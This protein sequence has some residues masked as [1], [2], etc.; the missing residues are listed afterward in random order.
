MESFSK[1]MDGGFL[2]EPLA[3]ERNPHDVANRHKSMDDLTFQQSST[4]TDLA[5]L[6]RVTRK[7]V[8]VSMHFKTISFKY[9]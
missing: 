8:L 4:G 1:S 9:I 6:L 3:D 5:R 2:G 7:I